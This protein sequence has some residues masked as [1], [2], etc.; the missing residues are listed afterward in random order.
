METGHAHFLAALASPPLLLA[1][2]S[3]V[4]DWANAPPIRSATNYSN[5]SAVRARALSYTNF[6]SQLT[7]T[8][9]WE[10]LREDIGFLLCRLNIVDLEF[11]SLNSLSDEVVS[12]VDMLRP[13]MKL[14]VSHQTNRTLIVH[15]DC[16][17]PLAETFYFFK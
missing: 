13:L 1:E 4:S 11:F 16:R 15:V 3:P 8:I 12:D 17:C 10:R 6:F 7:E 9:P 5:T 14:W 2:R